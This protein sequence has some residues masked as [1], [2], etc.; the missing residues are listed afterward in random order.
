M[1]KRNQFP[2]T[3]TINEKTNEKI[4]LED[5]SKGSRIISKRN[6]GM[7]DL[8]VEKRMVWHL[9]DSDSEATQ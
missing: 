4:L 6:N 3:Q 9:K 8:F 1:I 7:G 5:F 2:R